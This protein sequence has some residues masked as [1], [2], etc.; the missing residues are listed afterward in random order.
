M[1][2]KAMNKLGIRKSAFENHSAPPY[3]C[4][5]EQVI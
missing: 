1:N 4:N 2:K 5:L 3:V